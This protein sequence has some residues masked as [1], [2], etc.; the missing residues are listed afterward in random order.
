MMKTQTLNE[1]LADELTEVM[2]VVVGGPLNGESV[3]LSP[4]KDRYI[5]G[6]GSDTDIPLQDDTV[7]RRHF[8]ILFDEEVG[9]LR[10][11]AFQSKNGTYVGAARDARLL[12]GQEIALYEGSVFYAGDICIKVQGCRVE[13]VTAIKGTFGGL[14][15]ESM[16]MRK[17]LSRLQH[18]TQAESD[19]MVCGEVGVGKSELVRAMA[20]EI[21]CK[22]LTIDCRRTNSELDLKNHGEKIIYFDTVDALPESIQSQVAHELDRERRNRIFVFSC[23]SIDFLQERVKQGRFLDELYQRVISVKLTIPP[24]RYRLD[25]IVPLAE[26]FAT[27]AGRQSKRSLTIDET[28]WELLRSLPWP[29]NLIELRNLIRQAVIF[30]GGNPIGEDL[31]RECLL[32]DLESRFSEGKVGEFVV[33]AIECLR[34]C[35]TGQ[36]PIFDGAKYISKE[37]SR[38]CAEEVM[39]KT[40]DIQE[41]AKILQ[42]HE[43]TA[44]KLMNDVYDKNRE[45]PTDER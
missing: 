45:Q 8:E 7:S 25:D 23:L 30:S 22:V 37:F 34:R 18:V 13:K 20:R 40:E 5:G 26:H 33:N 1:E 38:I 31:L 10:L 27:Q 6:R 19:L 17:L 43:R 29:G 3:R 28:G 21:Q 4:D 14:V 2:L 39:R 16:S 44:K 35:E 24:L 41:I 32:M 15:C 9:R 36:T 42:C 12:P 11:R